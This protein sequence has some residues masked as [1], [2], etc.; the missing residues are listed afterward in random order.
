MLQIKTDSGNDRVKS[1]QDEI[2]T[3]KIVNTIT[4]IF[5]WLILVFWGVMIG[6][7]IMGEM[8]IT[9][10]NITKAESW[11][12]NACWS[13]ISEKIQIIKDESFKMKD[14]FKTPYSSR[15]LNSECIIPKK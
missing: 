10:E 12:E 1:L 2:W 15:Y 6:G 14:K 8:K 11:I 9:R 7:I 5:V 13:G 4:S 3:T